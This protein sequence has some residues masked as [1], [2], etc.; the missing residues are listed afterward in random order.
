MAK[1]QVTCRAGLAAVQDFTAINFTNK[2]SLEHCTQYMQD[3]NKPTFLS[4]LYVIDRQSGVRGGVKGGKMH[5]RAKQQ[6]S[7]QKSRWLT[8]MWAN[9]L[10][11][12]NG[13]GVV[14]PYG[15]P[16][17]L[18]VALGHQPGLMDS[19]GRHILQL[20]HPR[21]NV[22]PLQVVVL[23]SSARGKSASC[24]DNNNNN[25]NNNNNYNDTTTNRHHGHCS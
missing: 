8:P 25:N 2:N 9:K 3:S 16:K 19:P 15:D 4:K 5:S 24:D 22:L 10:G 14:Q 1:E 20:R 12:R 11:G 18:L 7:W 21:P 17:L 6:A 13:G 23:Q